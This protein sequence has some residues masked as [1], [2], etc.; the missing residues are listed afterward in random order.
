[1]LLEGLNRFL[2][3]IWCQKIIAVEKGG[4]GCLDE[5]YALIACMALPVILFQCYDLDA[6]VLLLIALEH[7]QRIVC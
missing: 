2:Q 1:M 5:W 6:V 7:V 3:G 4:E